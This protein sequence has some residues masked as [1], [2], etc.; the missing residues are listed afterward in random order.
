LVWDRHSQPEVEGFDLIE[1]KDGRAFERFCFPQRING[2]CIGVVVNLREVTERRQAETALRMGEEKYRLLWATAE[3]AIVIFGSD[4]IILEANAAVTT[5]LGYTPEELIGGDI[6]QIQ[7]ERLREGHRRGLQRYLDTGVRKIN[8]RAAEVPALHRDG[9]EIP[10]EVAFNHLHFDGRDLFAGFIRDISVRKQA[11]QAL[12]N[13]AAIVDSSRDAIISKTPEGIITS[14]NNGAERIFGYTAAEAI[15]RS[16]LMIIPPERADEEPRI[17]AR[18]GQG[19]A[20][21]HFETV[22]IRKDGQRIDVSITLS[23]IKDS[24][25]N[26][27]GISKIARDITERKQAEAERE[28][29]LSR[30][31]KARE[32]AESANRIKDEFLATLSHE[33]RTPLNAI[34]GWSSMISDGGLS[35]DDKVQGIEII[36]RNARLQA[37]LVE[38][39][40]DVSRIVT[41]KLRMDVQVVNLQTV[42]EDAVESM[43]PAI[44]AKGIRFQRVLDSGASMVAGDPNRLQQV[45]W[46]LLANAIKFTPRAGRVQV[47][48]E[49]V[50][51]HVE[52]IISDTG[53]GVD[54][55]I[56]PHIFERFRQADQSS[57][58]S[59][60]GLGLGLA[61][62]RHVVEMHGGAVEAD[63]PGLGMG[64][65][66]TV[67][68]PII[69]TRSSEVS[70]QKAEAR[71]HPTTSIGRGASFE[72]PDVLRGL[73][74][75]VVDDDNDARG[76]VT[77]VLETC[78]AK[79]T[80]AAC[81]AEALSKLQTSR[82]DVI[83]SDVG[84]PGEDGY[85]LI[86]KIRS[87][88]AEQGGQTPA[89]ALTAYARVEDRLH[90]LR[91]GFQ[92]HLSK[93][94][95]PAELVTVV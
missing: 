81:A 76:L 63:S 11:E 65:T 67:K 66:F 22:R 1:L 84:M 48:L 95:E 9:R 25:G 20:T 93:P 41:G 92:F 58:R 83:V 64:T 79:V 40:L 56:L 57:T 17:L 80:I 54:P 53:L 18:Q 55:A 12:A 37:Q 94:I 35:E 86:Q 50:N 70:S 26:V 60:G 52:I 45:V 51:S 39:I 62:V 6:A 21:D 72:C 15:G 42:I 28:L 31:Q 16:I 43:W 68:L 23:P 36:H 32:E 78:K 87:L 73:H 61:I 14:W 89:A 90:A 27:I 10:V 75:L 24:A 13:F 91:S 88:P 77:T 7:P 69:A 8:W 5:I 71:V 3:D 44:N 33:L 49:R 2:E 74:V 38:D 47:R 19:Q 30:E 34:L 46:N 29:L 85:S 4:N 59:H 82:P